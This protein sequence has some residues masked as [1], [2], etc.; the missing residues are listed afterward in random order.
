M[1]LQFTGG[2]ASAFVALGTTLKYGPELLN[3]FTKESVT[4]MELKTAFDK[5]Q[6]TALGT[7]KS[8]ID[9]SKVIRKIIAQMKHKDREYNAIV[10]SLRNG[11]EK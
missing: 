9:Q 4:F 5:S 3:S 2:I 7:Y 10:R 11:K 6:C 1:E 8:L